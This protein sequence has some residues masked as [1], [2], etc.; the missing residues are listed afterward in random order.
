MIKISY[1]KEVNSMEKRVDQTPL[2]EGAQDAPEQSG[3]HFA[4][5]GRI[6]GAGRVA[7]KLVGVWRLKR[8]W[9]QYDHE[10]ALYPLGEDAR[11]YIMYTAD[12]YMSGTMQRAQVEPFRSADRLGASK[13][14]KANA[15]ESYVTY[16]GR[17]QVEG[18][19]AYHRVELSLLPNWIGDEQVRRIEWQVDERVRL[20][21][22]WR[23]DGR[24]RV[25]VVEW[26]RAR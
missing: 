14:E 25:A 10:P 26:E 8:Y 22:E 12:G 3:L 20:V 2:Y 9:T 11:G 21:A 16:C 24:R 7:N 17:Y 4:H 18:D 23:F 13:D 1:M 6:D 19:T 5:S 15:F